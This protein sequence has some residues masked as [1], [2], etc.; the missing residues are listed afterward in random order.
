MTYKEYPY[1][2]KV[3]VLHH[4]EGI[5]VMESPL[6]E[7]EIIA[8]SDDKKELEEIGKKTYPRDGSGWD[9]HKWCI[10]VNTST[11]GGK[12]LLEKFHD[13]VAHIQNKIDEHPEDYST[14][15]VDGQK[16][17]TAK[18]ILDS[19][20]E[21]Q[22]PLTSIKFIVFDVSDKTIEDGE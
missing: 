15:E 3:Y 5:G 20:K 8:A 12:V 9:Y 19:S 14:I 4:T 6:Y 10:N 17:T 16:W 13:K 18:C 7:R 22:S 1:I 21:T 2:D 11:E